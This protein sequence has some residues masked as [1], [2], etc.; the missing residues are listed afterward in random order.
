MS[1]GIQQLFPLCHIK[2]P[3]CT[4]QTS[5][6]SGEDVFGEDLNALVATTDGMV[7]YY[8]VVFGRYREAKI[9]NELNGIDGIITVAP[10]YEN[11]AISLGIL[12]KGSEGDRTRPVLNVTFDGNRNENNRTKIETFVYYL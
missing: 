12:H 3:P 7:G 2:R 4:P 5:P 9:L 8:A 11:T 10:T 1:C 6:R